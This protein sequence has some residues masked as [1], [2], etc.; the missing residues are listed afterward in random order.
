MSLYEIDH[1]ATQA[2]IDAIGASGLRA[3]GEC[4]RRSEQIDKQVLEMLAREEREKQTIDERAEQAKQHEPPAR[5]TPKRSTLALGAE[6]FREAGSP[7]RARQ[8]SQA[9][10]GAQGTPATRDTS[11]PAADAPKPS[12]ANRTL[13]L[14]TPE[15]R[16]A[17]AA[18]ERHP[19]TPAAKRR[20]AESGDDL[21]PRT[22]LR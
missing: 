17:D 11:G 4:A 9:T 22:W 18:D 6:E 1:A 2:R 8:E 7:N 10:R 20:P 12:P 16:E 15:D 14:G 5:P 3:L 13:R 19:S 21:S